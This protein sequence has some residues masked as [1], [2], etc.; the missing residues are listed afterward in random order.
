MPANQ[1][2]PRFWLTQQ[3]MR[4]RDQAARYPLEK[5]TYGTQEPL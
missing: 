4:S 2:N 3:Y 5:G 1:S